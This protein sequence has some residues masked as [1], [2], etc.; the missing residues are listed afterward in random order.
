MT[1]YESLN[2]ISPFT[3]GEASFRGPQRYLGPHCDT[4][5]STG[6]RCA[7]KH[8]S[9]YK[10]AVVGCPL[11]VG[12]LLSEMVVVRCE[13]R[14]R[15]GAGW[16]L[17][18]ASHRNLRRSLYWRSETRSQV[19]RGLPTGHRS[20]PIRRGTRPPQVVTMLVGP[21]GAIGC[22][23]RIGSVL[24]DYAASGRRR[25]SRCVPLRF[26]SRNLRHAFQEPREKGTGRE[27]GL[28]F[29]SV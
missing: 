1:H 7:C 18:N 20:R 25:R 27:V 16:P 29:S 5:R 10:M 14:G 6:A 19:R 21:Q 22:S 2:A 26:T 9:S 4:V 13:Y 8:R 17:K 24:E 11:F 12:K 15:L 23:R 28:N 3:G